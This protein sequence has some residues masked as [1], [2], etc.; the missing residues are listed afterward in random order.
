ML[1]IFSILIIIVQLKSVIILFAK[2][3]NSSN[4]ISMINWGSHPHSPHRQTEMQRHIV[5]IEA[6]QN[7]NGS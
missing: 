2:F 4:K 3:S 6:F 7:Q 1:A 5:I